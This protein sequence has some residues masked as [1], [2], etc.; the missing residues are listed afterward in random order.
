MNIYVINHLTHIFPIRSL[1]IPFRSTNNFEF[2]NIHLTE[3]NGYVEN[4]TN[5]STH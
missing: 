4:C 1:N 5:S 2:N 3:N